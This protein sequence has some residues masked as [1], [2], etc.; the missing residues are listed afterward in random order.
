MENVE[1]TILAPGD[2]LKARCT[3]CKQNNDHI[4]VSMA[5]DVPEK[6]QCGVCDRK[7]KYRP[8]TEPKKPPVKR[9]PVHIEAEKKQWKALGLNSESKKV[10]EYSMSEPYKVKAVINHPIF[11]LGMVQRIAGA[12]KVEVLFEAGKKMMRCK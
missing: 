6:V 7:H 8:P 5:G 3:K 9:V 2:P 1:K 11:G 4:V 10:S 12:Q